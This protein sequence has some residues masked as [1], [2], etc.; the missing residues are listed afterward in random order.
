MERHSITAFHGKI[1]V[2]VGL[3]MYCIHFFSITNLWIKRVILISFFFISNYIQYLQETITAP[4]HLQSF[5][6]QDNVK[7]GDDKDFCAVVPPFEDSYLCKGKKKILYAIVPNNYN[8]VNKTDFQAARIFEPILNWEKVPYHRFLQS[9]TREVFVPRKLSNHR[10]TDII[11]KFHP[12]T[13][14]KK[15]YKFRIKLGETTLEKS[16][17]FA[18]PYINQAAVQMKFKKPLDISDQQKVHLMFEAPIELPI[19]Q[20]KILIE[21]VGID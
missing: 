11:I 15:N 13:S 7:Y 21:W 10:V 18:T 20:E 6:W 3:A 14:I 16:F 19:S 5:S 9:E 17:T 12:N 2:L 4:F 1:L 8:Y